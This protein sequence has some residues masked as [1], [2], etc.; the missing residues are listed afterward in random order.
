MGSVF[1]T[2]S[3]D[4]EGARIALE[5]GP[6][7]D[8]SMRVFRASREGE[9]WLVPREKEAFLLLLDAPAAN[10]MGAAFA[11]SHATRWRASTIT[12][13]NDVAAMRKLLPELESV[14]RAWPSFAGI[15]LH[16]LDAD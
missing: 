14:W 16:G 3:P 13:R 10:P 12:F 7:P 15:A 8:E 2:V 6:I 9:L 4:I 11:Y 5:V 1:T